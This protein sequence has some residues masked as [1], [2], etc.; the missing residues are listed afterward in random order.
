MCVVREDLPACGS[1][2][3]VGTVLD[4]NASCAYPAS[5]VLASTWNHQAAASGASNDGVNASRHVGPLAWQLG[6]KLGHG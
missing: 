4:L 1:N 6:Q 3:E 5:P 2:A